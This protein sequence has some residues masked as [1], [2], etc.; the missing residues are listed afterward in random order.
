MTA[1]KPEL[2]E[3]VAL[4]PVEALEALE[5]PELLHAAARRHVSAAAAATAAIRDL[6]S[7]PILSPERLRDRG[8]AGAGRHSRLSVTSGPVGYAPQGMMFIMHMVRIDVK[9]VASLLL[10]RFHQRRRAW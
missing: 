5:V 8:A 4:E 6:F 10:D 7:T 2:A 3:L 1:L 9:E